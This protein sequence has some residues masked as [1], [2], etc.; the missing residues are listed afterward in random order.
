MVA[1]SQVLFYVN[2]CLQ[3]YLFR[4]IVTINKGWSLVIIKE[5]KVS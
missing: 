5:W 4:R 1:L 2:F 3:N